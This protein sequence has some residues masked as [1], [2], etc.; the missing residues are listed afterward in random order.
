MLASHQGNG[1]EGTWTVTSFGD[2]QVGIVGGGGGQPLPYQF[3]PVIRPKG[4]EEPRE[5]AGAEIGIH[6]GDFL[7][8]FRFVALTQAARYKDLVQAA[9]FLL[10]YL[11]KNGIDA[12]L[13]G[14]GNKAAGIDHHDVPGGLM[15]H[16][17][18]AG[19]QLPHQ[20]LGIIAV[21][22]TAQCDH[23]YGVLLCRLGPH[24]RN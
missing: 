8:Q 5:V 15:H 16:I 12:F 13:L 22:G 11:F 9:G 19:P 2:L 18:L 3:V 7:L 17:L 24:I 21:L 10:P 6:I 1:A 14:V 20:H 4:L 23:V